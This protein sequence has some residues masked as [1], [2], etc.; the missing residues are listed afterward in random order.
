MKLQKNN[1]RHFFHLLLTGFII[2]TLAWFVL[3]AV[4]LYFGYDIT[5]AIGPV[6]FDI[7]VISFK[8]LV[9]PGS[10]VGSLGGGFVFTRI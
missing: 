6:G 7:K 3:E 1:I 10:I 4:L 2:G 5:I 9:N 8:I